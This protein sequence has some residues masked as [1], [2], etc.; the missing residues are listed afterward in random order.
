MRYVASANSGFHSS[1]SPVFGSDFSTAVVGRSKT[2][3]SGIPPIRSKCSGQRAHYRFGALVVDQC[4]QGI[5][6][7]LQTA[8]EELHLL[9]PAV[10]A[11]AH[12]HA[13]KMALAAL[14]RHAFEA[15]DRAHGQRSQFPHQGVQGGLAAPIAGRARGGALER[16]QSG[17]RLQDGS[18]QFTV[19]EGRPGPPPGGP[20]PVGPSLRRLHPLRRREPRPRA[21]PDERSARKPRQFLPPVPLADRP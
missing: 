5:A 13:P 21:G 10:A 12:P 7:E 14:A 4:Q 3:S 17:Q 1:T 8:A 20:T 9:E 15:A 18:H 19:L 6:R 2:A 16:L 11:P